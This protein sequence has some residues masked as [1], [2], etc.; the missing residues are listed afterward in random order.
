MDIH[1]CCTSMLQVKKERVGYRPSGFAHFRFSIAP[2]FG[3]RISCHDTGCM[4]APVQRLAR[5]RRSSR[6]V[7][8]SFASSKHDPQI[9]PR[10][11]QIITPRVSQT[12]HHSPHDIP[13]SKTLPDPDLIPLRTPYILHPN[14][15][16]KLIRTCPSIHSCDS[17]RS[18]LRTES[19]YCA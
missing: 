13:P 15:T 11:R 6:G 10:R 17:H 2:V 8:T 3:Q 4:I 16:P 5:S 19:G 7:L 12:H 1:C 18:L 14:H 9:V